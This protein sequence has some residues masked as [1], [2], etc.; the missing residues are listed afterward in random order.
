MRFEMI[1]DTI[2]SILEKAEE[3]H[4]P[5]QVRVEIVLA[6]LKRL[7]TDLKLA[8]IRMFINKTTQDKKH[9]DEITKL[10]RIEL[11]IAEAALDEDFNLFDNEMNGFTQAIVELNNRQPITFDDSTKKAIFRY[12]LAAEYFDIRYNYLIKKYINGEDVDTEAYT[13]E[14]IQTF[15]YYEQLSQD[16][17][18]GIRYSIS[19]LFGET[20]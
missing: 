9:L 13:E 15:P 4:L 20:L 17:Q 1:T 14:R 11:N 3:L 5:H 6:R 10:C 18:A 19:K 7:F 12:T 2:Q 8:M 16:D